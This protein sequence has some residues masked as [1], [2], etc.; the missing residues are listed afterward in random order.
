[1]EEKERYELVEEDFAY[2][3]V[4]NEKHKTYQNDCFDFSNIC[5]L[6]NR[7]DKENQKLCQQ[8]VNLNKENNKLRE[9]KD[10]ILRVQAE[11]YRF[12][13]KIQQL[14]ELPKKIVEDFYDEIRHRAILEDDYCPDHNLERKYG[15]RKCLLENIRTTILKK[16][17]VKR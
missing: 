5:D 13:K 16:Y 1:M 17:G 4:D 6:L 10:D 15:V 7:Q 8:I 2:A 12:Y 3:I 11:P 14:H 9:F